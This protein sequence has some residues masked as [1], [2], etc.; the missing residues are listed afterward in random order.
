[1]YPI[2]DFL[3]SSPT[4]NTWSKKWAMPEIV[5]PIGEDL[6]EI[7]TRFYFFHTSKSIGRQSMPPY[8]TVQY[9]PI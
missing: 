3:Y 4:L 9:D 5:G 8:G 2:V 1:M 7:N 6:L